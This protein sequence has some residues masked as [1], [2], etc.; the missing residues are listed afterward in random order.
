MD[1]NTETL[2]TVCLVPVWC[3]NSSVTNKTKSKLKQTQSHYM[4]ESASNLDFTK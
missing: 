2:R 1:V 4:S 3:D